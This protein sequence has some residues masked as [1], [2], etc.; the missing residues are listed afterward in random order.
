MEE[1][2]D[3]GPVEV[4]SKEHLDAYWETNN[5]GG[6]YDCTKYEHIVNGN[7]IATINQNEQESERNWSQRRYL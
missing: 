7:I 6:H 5:S 2:E 4:N 3:A 1:A